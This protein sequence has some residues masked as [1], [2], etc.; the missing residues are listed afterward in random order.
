MFKSLRA[1]PIGICVAITVLSLL[2]LALVTFF[3]VRND[4]LAQLDEHVGGL[5]RL[6]ADEV[7]EWVREKQRITS[8]LKVA[9]EQPDPLPMLRAIKQAGA[10]D[11]VYFTH[12]DKRHMALTKVPDGYDGTSRPWYQQAAQAGGPGTVARRRWIDAG[13][14][15][16][17]NHGLGCWLLVDC[18]QRALSVYGQKGFQRNKI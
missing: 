15:I 14:G 3:A 11:L 5:T 18:F 17:V 4:T 7:S 10:F 16:A 1:R 8:S 2:A 9:T 12:A 6:H 13:V